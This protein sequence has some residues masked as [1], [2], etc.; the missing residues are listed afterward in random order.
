MLFRSGGWLAWAP[1][2]AAQEPGLDVRTRSWKQGEAVQVTVTLPDTVHT[3]PVV[4]AFGT[5]WPGG[6]TSASQWT[7][8]VGI[9]LAQK[10]GDYTVDVETDTGNGPAH[11][12]RAVHVDAAR[13]RRRV[14]RVAPDF[15]NPSPDELARIKADTALTDRIYAERDRKSTRLNSSHSQQSRMP[16]SA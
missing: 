9:D 11:L 4:R 6:R 5:A 15:V 12:T 13:F 7:A 8:L 16:S 3:D 1:V 14:L 2:H 10:A